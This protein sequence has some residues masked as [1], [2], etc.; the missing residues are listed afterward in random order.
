MKKKFTNLISGKS[1]ILW[2]IYSVL[3]SFFFYLYG[4]IMRTS[5]EAVLE[6]YRFGAPSF[7]HFQATM[8]ISKVFSVFNPPPNPRGRKRLFSSSKQNCPI[9]SGGSKHLKRI[10]VA[11]KVQIQACACF[12]LP[13][14]N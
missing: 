6:V 5:R 10:L 11:M 1:I 9:M 8:I 12:M 3:F 14:I 2:K 7:T 4:F 13:V